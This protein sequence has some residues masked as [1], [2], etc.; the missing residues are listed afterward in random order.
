MDTEI[1]YKYQV[2]SEIKYGNL[3]LDREVYK[4]YTD[5][6]STKGDIKNLNRRLLHCH[7]S[8][9]GDKQCK[10]FLNDI[11]DFWQNSGE[12]FRESYDKSGFKA[13]HEFL[14]KQEMVEVIFAMY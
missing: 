12:G 9:Y 2:G 6:Y 3:T 5:S 13:V 10:M 11:A 1:Y 4:K 8:S 7:L 14:M